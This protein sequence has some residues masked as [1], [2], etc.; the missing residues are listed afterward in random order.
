MGVYLFR[1]GDVVGTDM[2]GLLG[3]VCR[4]DLC[5]KKDTC[6]MLVCLF[7]LLAGVICASAV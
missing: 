4:T 3:W 1:V 6:V 2:V 7:A 5:M